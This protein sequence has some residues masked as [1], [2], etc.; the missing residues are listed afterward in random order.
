M[1]ERC[2]LLADPLSQEHTYDTSG[3]FVRLRDD[4]KWADIAERNGSVRSHP[5][6]WLVHSPSDT[7]NPV[8]AGKGRG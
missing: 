2:R 1:H 7:R 3:V 6:A 8:R 5:V 4:V